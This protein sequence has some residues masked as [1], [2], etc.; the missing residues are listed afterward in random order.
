MRDK[1][2]YEGGASNST[3]TSED[4]RT[5]ASVPSDAMTWASTWEMMKRTLET[6]ATRNKTQLTEAVA[7][8]GKPSK[9]PK[10]SR[11]IQMVALTPG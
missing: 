7:N 3:R 5:H 11:T 6:F 4:S 2:C 9:N 10:I 8:P 1:D